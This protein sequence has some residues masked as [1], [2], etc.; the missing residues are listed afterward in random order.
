MLEAEIFYFIEINEC[1]LFISQISIMV[2][3][4]LLYEIMEFCVPVFITKKK[5]EQT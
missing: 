4:I 3:C 2:I 1:F 5:K